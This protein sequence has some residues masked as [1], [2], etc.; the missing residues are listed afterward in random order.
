M[1]KAKKWLVW[2][3]VMK[4]SKLY[5]KIPAGE[6]WCLTCPC[7]FCNH[8]NQCLEDIEEVF[9][10]TLICTGPIS[11]ISFPP[12]LMKCSM[13]VLR[14]IDVWSTATYSNL[15]HLIHFPEKYLGRFE[16]FADSSPHPSSSW[17]SSYPHLRCFFPDQL[18][19]DSTLQLDQRTSS[20]KGSSLH[21]TAFLYAHST[22]RSNVRVL[23][24]PSLLSKL[25]HSVFQ[26]HILFQLI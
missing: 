20:I 23:H 9:T 6:G 25:S 17:L 24:F 26:V 18:C 10:L 21:R 22:L 14:V 3:F 7:I 19:C 8:P 5:C 13:C 2:Y 11:A 1:Y 4:S 16:I 12:G 15:P